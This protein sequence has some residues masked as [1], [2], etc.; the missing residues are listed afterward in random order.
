M[1]RLCFTGLIVVAVAMLATPTHA[2]DMPSVWTDIMT[3][4]KLAVCVIPSYQPY[5][6]KDSAGQWQGFAPEMGR[7]VAKS[8]HVEPEFVE[9]TQG[10]IVLDLQ[11]NKC[12]TYFAFNATPERALAIDFAGPM[13]TL[14]FIFIDRKGWQ[15]PGNQWADFNDPKIRICYVIG[16]SQEQ[17]IKRFDPKS[18]QIGLAKVDDC[19]LAVQTGR[20]DTYLAATL[21]GLVTKQKNPQLGDLVFPQPANALPSYAGIRIDSD[22]RFQ[23]FLQRWSEYNRANGNVAQWLIGAL[24]KYGVSPATIPADIQF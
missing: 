13:Y 7:D 2:A 8:L 21:D 15:P 4:K 22:G 11:S 16:A 6:W 1:R 23:K 9:T 19:L 24:A 17:Q 14:G 12:Q 3:K 20:A 18:T 10:T 5:A